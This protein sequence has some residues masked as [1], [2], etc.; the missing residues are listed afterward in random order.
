MDLPPPLDSRGASTTLAVDSA[1][2]REVAGGRE[3]NRACCAADAARL[4]W[5]ALIVKRC[6]AE[7]RQRVLA[8][9]D[10]DLDVDAEV[11]AHRMCVDS[12]M[13]TFGVGK[14]AATVLVNLADRLAV[15]PAVF[16]AWSSG[17]LDI[18][19]VRVLAEATDVLDDVTAR[20]VAHQVLAW[21]G[22]GPWQGPAPRKWRSK[23]EEAVVAADAQ[24][25][26][27]RR[28]AAIAARRVRSWT[29]GDGSAVLAVHAGKA[30][31]ELADQVITDL[32]HSWPARDA[33]G[34][35]LTMDQRRA[36]AFIGL[37]RAVRDHSVTGVPALNPGVATSAGVPAGSAFT[38]G[39]PRVP[40]R[41]GHDLGLVLHADT[42]F[43]DGPAA[44]A[45]GQLRGLGRP[46]A[47]DPGSARTL[48][49][50]RLR[51]GTGVQVLVV[52]D[53][54]AVQHVV[55]LD[56]HTAEHCQSR[57]TL[58]AAVT[59]ELADAPALEVDTHDPS[60]AIARHVRAAAPTCSFYDCPRQARSCDL[61]HD[62]PW[63][64]GPTS[65]TNLDPK[66]RRHHNA[67]TYGAMQTRLTAGPGNGPRSV[68]WTLP[69]G[70]QV[71]TTPEPLPGVRLHPTPAPAPVAG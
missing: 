44:D 53:S 3:A 59:K 20:A 9:G 25:A 24:A 58:V 40:V 36:D 31:I 12:V 68:H 63:P 42:L 7:V 27:S 39:L 70:I 52:D 28:A 5:V 17:I 34:V 10:G 69:A 48:A 1:A 64:R 54:G 38:P 55:R 45:T 33:D 67:K 71:T 2:A 57:E 18:T 16:D 51:E 14:N 6:R 41:R 35:R 29:E 21:A 43:G 22:D 8:L 32:A 26:A 47:I 56:K 61:D 13:C 15:L 19:R 11:F 49:R 46:D 62:T 60:E 65:M 66:C 23:V 50:K 37:L 30:D 4:R